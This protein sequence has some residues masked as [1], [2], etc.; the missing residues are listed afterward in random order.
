MPIINLS[1]EVVGYLPL[2]LGIAVFLLLIGIAFLIARF[3]A[4]RKK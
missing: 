2:L 1:N 4:K 3:A